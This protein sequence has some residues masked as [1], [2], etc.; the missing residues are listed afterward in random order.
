MD[1]DVQPGSIFLSFPETARRLWFGERC[2]AA[3]RGV[4]PVVLNPADRVLSPREIAAQ[5]GGCRVIVLDRLT[6]V[7]PDL[8]DL[9]PDLSAVVRAGV[10]IRWIDTVAASE[11]G[12]LVTQVRPA[13]G[14]AVAELVVGL[15]IDAARSITA[16]V[17]AYRG[18]TVPPVLPGQQIRGAT[19]GLIGYGHIARHLAGILSAIGAEIVV[20]DPH[21]RADGVRQVDLPTLLALSDYV[22]PLA[23]ATPET[24][25]MLDAAAFRAM[26]PTAWLV[27]C[28]RGDLVDEE[29]LAR[30]LD[31]GEIAGAAMDVG[32]AEDQLPTPTLAAHPRVIATPHV[33]GIT[34]Q[35]F[36]AHGMQAVEQAR[37]V[38]AGQLPP[39]AVNADRA[40]RLFSSA[41]RTA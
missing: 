2:L 37:M 35:S 30:A 20:F 24:R 39:G 17:T 21:A 10:D 38:L 33:G 34:E 27:N 22:V 36:E 6:P 23:V 19:V 14:A 8:L 13:Y 26:K 7:G 29:A 28:S 11:R 40:T 32:W 5:A 12:V 4:A 18:G 3:L 25:N 16:Y 31:A 41:A 9:L 15:M 1:G